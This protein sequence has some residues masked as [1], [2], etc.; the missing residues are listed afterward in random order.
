MLTMETQQVL[1]QVDPGVLLWSKKMVKHKKKE[2]K[3]GTKIMM[4]AL[5]PLK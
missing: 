4:F 3:N 1:A 2:K 5:Q